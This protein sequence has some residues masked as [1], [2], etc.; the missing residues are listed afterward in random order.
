MSLSLSQLNKKGEREREGEREGERK[1][2]REGDGEGER[3]GQ[4]QGEADRKRWRLETPNPREG[5]KRFAFVLRG[6]R[7][8]FRRCGHRRR[9]QRCRRSPNHR[10]RRIWLATTAAVVPSNDTT[11]V[12]RRRLIFSN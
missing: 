2:E 9:S 3:E 4:R 8:R 1:R 11:D 10:Q 6:K 12:P 7:T 5:I